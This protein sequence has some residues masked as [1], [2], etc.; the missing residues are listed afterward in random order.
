MY[1]FVTHTWNAIKGKCFHDCSYCYMKRWGNLKDVR[2]DKK[3]LKTDLG[4]GNFIFVGSSNDIFA[5]NIPKDWTRSVLSHCSVYSGNKYLFQTK[6]PY[7]V[8]EFVLPDNS[9][10]CTTIE[11]NRY[12]PEIMGNSP[13]PIDRV[14]AFS[15]RPYSKFEGW[16]PEDIYDYL[17]KRKRR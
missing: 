14:L 7:R 2:L 3:E 15:N 8:G 11:T 13:K 4:S 1:E 12:Y 16:K 9:I 17:N 6:N 10:L 5:E